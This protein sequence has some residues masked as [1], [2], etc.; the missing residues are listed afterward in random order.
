MKPISGKRIIKILEARGWRYVRSRGS[1]RFYRRDDSPELFDVPFH[2]NEDLSP[3]T[4]RDI[5]GKAGLT[6]KDL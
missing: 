1:H 6:A 5:M 2:A 3:G 4:Q